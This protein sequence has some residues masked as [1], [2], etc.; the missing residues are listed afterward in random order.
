MSYQSL[1]EHLFFSAASIRSSRNNYIYVC[2]NWENCYRG[3]P[4][5]TL[6]EG[7]I[8][9]DCMSRGNYSPCR[10]CNYQFCPREARLCWRCEGNGVP[11]WPGVPACE[12]PICKFRRRASKGAKY[13]VVHECKMARC[14]E[15][16]VSGVRQRYCWDHKCSAEGCAEVR[17]KGRYCA[18]HGCGKKWCSGWIAV[19]CREHDSED[20][21]MFGGVE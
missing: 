5:P 15:S 11:R 9:L 8:C 21:D 3:V 14:R 16:V 17:G 6:I 13:C 10:N 2:A 7:D 1:Q 19:N 4:Q 12:K 20:W 18:W